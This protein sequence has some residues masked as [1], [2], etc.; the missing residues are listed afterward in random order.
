MS[1][2]ERSQGEFLLGCIGSYAFAV[3]KVRNRIK[4]LTVVSLKPDKPSR[5][6]VLLSY[7]LEP[8]RDLKPGQPVP[9]HI[10]YLG[11]M[12]IARTFL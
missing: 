7:I 9:T 8:F 12:Q 1:G 3:T 5:G 2:E 4:R 6:N 10:N 11:Y